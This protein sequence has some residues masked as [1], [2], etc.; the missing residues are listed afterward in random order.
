[1]DQ[2]MAHGRFGWLRFTLVTIVLLIGIAVLAVAMT[3]L[4]ANRGYARAFDLRTQLEARHGDLDRYRVSP[5]GTIPP[6]RMVRFLEVR[7]ALK[8]RC[9]AVTASTEPFQR[10]ARLAKARG[11]EPDLAGIFGGVT[12][13]AGR[14]PT[15]AFVFGDYVTARNGALLEQEMGLGE[16]MWIY[17]VAYFGLMGQAPLPVLERKSEA[18]IFEGRVFPTIA[19]AIRRHVADAALG[20]GPWVDELG[21]L[22]RDPE[23]IPFSSGLPIELAASLAPYRT[24]LAERACP[25]AAELD[26]TIT[27]PRRFAGYDHR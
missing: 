7:R 11:G 14:L 22:Q 6:D 18:S 20:G 2:P 25:A 9:A 19:K 10:V 12:A 21:R 24:T 3:A 1:M 27:V 16:Y 13:A 8:S 26:L 4:L 23:R 17:S 5:D 15:L